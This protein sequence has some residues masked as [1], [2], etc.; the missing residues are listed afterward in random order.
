MASNFVVPPCSGTSHSSSRK[1]S[2]PAAIKPYNPYAF[3]PLHH[4]WTLMACK[5]SGCLYKFHRLSEQVIDTVMSSWWESTK[6]QYRTYLMR[7]HK[8]SAYRDRCYWILT[9]SFQTGIS[10]S[11]FN[12]A[13]S[14]LSA[15]IVFP[16]DTPAGGNLL[17]VRF[18]R[19]GPLKKVHKYLGRLC[20]VRI[21]TQIWACSKIIIE[22]VLLEAHHT[23]NVIIRSA[24]S[25]YTPARY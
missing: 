22:G 1:E 25:N 10:Y 12:T 17:V 4:K 9:E 3:H 2:A 15:V 14:A 20:C 13:W 19:G 5:S 8:F 16:D 7:W 6:K 24:Y 21:F 11:W 18:A 23:A